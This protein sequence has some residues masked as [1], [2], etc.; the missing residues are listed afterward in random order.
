[1]KVTFLSKWTVLFLTLVTAA[2][3]GLGYYLQVMSPQQHPWYALG[4]LLAGVAIY[5]LAWIIAALDAIQERKW[6]WLLGLIVLL[7]LWIGPLL[8]SLF[9]PRNTK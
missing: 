7:P 9:G 6:G 2:L 1:M 8:Y 3:A 5:G 4:A